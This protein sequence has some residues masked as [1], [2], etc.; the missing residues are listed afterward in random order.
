MNL[1]VKPRWCFLKVYT[2]GYGE[3]MVE[4][5]ARTVAHFG[6]PSTV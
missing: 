4:G 3:P 5:K 2:D 6:N 1:L